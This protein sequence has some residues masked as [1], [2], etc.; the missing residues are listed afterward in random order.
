ML[1]KIKEILI[2]NRYI[3]KEFHMSYNDEKIKFDFENVYVNEKA[4][5][6]YILVEN[7]ISNEIIE[8]YHNRILCFQNWYDD[9]ILIY[10]INLILI[11]QNRKENK[12]LHDLIYKY[13]QDGHLC[14][15]IFINSKYD[16]DELELDILPFKPL[17]TVQFKNKGDS[18]KKN[19]IELL[20]NIDMY[21]KLV[22]DNK[23]LDFE[24][25]IDNL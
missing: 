11:Y 4:T 13:E 15:K 16:F 8:S 21:N 10:N 19:M 9:D 2:S 18:L 6:M 14:R 23:S 22:I 12:E 1:E 7:N 17:G 25:I 3:K 24:G 5:E 20:G